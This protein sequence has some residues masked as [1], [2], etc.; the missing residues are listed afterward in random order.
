MLYKQSSLI[1]SVSQLTLLWSIHCWFFEISTC[2]NLPTIRAQKMALCSQQVTEMYT[3]QGQ[4]ETDIG[5]T[6]AH[7]QFPSVNADLAIYSEVV[8]VFR[9]CMN[10]SLILGIKLEFSPCANLDSF[11]KSWQIQYWRMVW[12]IIVKLQNI[13][14]QYAKILEFFL[15]LL[16]IYV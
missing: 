9:Q 11:R 3:I 15:F 2:S 12:I 6:L 16:L 14:L 4:V 13:L 10:V 5:N 7:H 8:D 1:A